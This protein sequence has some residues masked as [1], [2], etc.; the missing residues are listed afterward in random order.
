M[1]EMLFRQNTYMRDADARVVSHTD[2]GGIVLDRTIFYAS[3][4]GQP[5][6]CG[7]L[8]WAGARLRIATT[9]K[10]EGDAIVL[11]PDEPASLPPVGTLLTQSLDWERRYRHMRVHTALHLLSVVVPLPVSG[12]SIGAEKGRLDFDMPDAVIDR[13]ALGQTL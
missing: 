10:G 3:G 9:V 5:G 4:G 7:L 1:S 2:E 8:S 12:G 6:D 13:H 11:V